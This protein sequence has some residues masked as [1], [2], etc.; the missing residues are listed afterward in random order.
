MWVLG[1][2]LI[3]ES[4]RVSTD[5][6]DIRAGSLEKQRLSGWFLLVL[7]RSSPERA[8]GSCKCVSA[9]GIS[10]G[11]PQGSLHSLLDSIG[12]LTYDPL[13]DVRYHPSL[14]GG[15]PFKD[16]LAYFYSWFLI[17]FFIFSLTSVV[18]TLETLETIEIYKDGNNICLKSHPSH[19]TA[20][21]YMSVYVICLFLYLLYINVF[22][23][24]LRSFWICLVYLFLNVTL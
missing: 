3:S 11:L 12:F 1:S 20:T 5:R 13:L 23:V 2:V 17:F 10:P 18:H 22:F 14:G 24:S 15:L 7:Q 6:R 21:I 9:G 16:N 8:G 19:T 4:L